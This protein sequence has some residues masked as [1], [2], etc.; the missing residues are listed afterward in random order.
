MMPS[1]SC[2]TILRLEGLPEIEAIPSARRK[3]TIS[4]SIQDDGRITVRFPTR[5]KIEDAENFVCLKAEWLKRKIA[6]FRQ[7]PRTHEPQDFYNGK[8][9]PY[10]GQYFRMRLVEKNEGTDH[11]EVSFT[12]DEFILP[13]GLKED[14]RDAFLAWYKG[15]SRNILASAIERYSPI[16]NVRPDAIKVSGAKSRWGSCSA[17]DTLNFSWRIAALPQDIIDYIVVHE[18]AHLKHK[19]HGPLFWNTVASVIE[20]YKRRNRWLKDHVGRFFI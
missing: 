18:L 17:K 8:T 13:E 2:S 1:P 19:N 9:L 4:L 12:G 14:A 5:M 11:K 16:L 20:D 10:L 3:R 6:A 7:D 15:A